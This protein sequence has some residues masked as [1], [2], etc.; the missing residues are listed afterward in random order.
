[1]P[2]IFK[3]VRFFA[4][5]YCLVSGVRLTSD[6]ISQE[7]RDGTLGFLFLTPLRGYDVILGKLISKGV[8]PLYA[9]LVIVPLVWLVALVGGVGGGEL[10]Y[11]VIAIGNTLFLSLAVGM[12]VSTFL[13]DRR[14]CEAIASG[15]VFVL[16]FVLLP[17]VDLLVHSSLNNSYSFWSLGSSLIDY[18]VNRVNALANPAFSSPAGN[19]AALVSN[20]VKGS[21]L[22]IDN[23]TLA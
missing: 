1:M 9:M 14:R 3:T 12:T 19:H 16:F 8:L 5:I 20:V 17:L 21:V 4:L 10:F 15:L 6:C 23:Y 22:N 18:L 2:S 7:K 11:S 13:R